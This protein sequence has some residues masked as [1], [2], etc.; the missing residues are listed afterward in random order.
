MPLDDQNT[1]GHRGQLFQKPVFLPA[2]SVNSHRSHYPLYVLLSLA[3]NKITTNLLRPRYKIS[4]TEEI[5]SAL[6]RFINANSGGR[7][8]GRIPYCE[9]ILN[10]LN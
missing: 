8:Y 2:Y 1:Q 10:N 5:K 9:A 6:K 3:S 7:G 4:I